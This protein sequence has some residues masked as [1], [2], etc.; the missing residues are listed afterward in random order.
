VGG[1]V[2]WLLLED[3]EEEEEECIL[4][5]IM[6][7]KGR[8]EGGRK[9]VQAT[10][11]TARNLSGLFTSFLSPCTCRHFPKIGKTLVHV[12]F[13]YFLFP[14]TRFSGYLPTLLG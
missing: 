8:R 3:E 10:F 2:Q 12:T 5:R 9:I 1:T 11:S 6:V 7:I 4:P 14:L 13:F